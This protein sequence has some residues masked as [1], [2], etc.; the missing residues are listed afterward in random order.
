[1]EKVDESALSSAARALEKHADD[2]ERFGSWNADAFDLWVQDGARKVI[3]AYQ[4][5]LDFASKH[6]GKT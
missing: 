2:S 5:A 6:G 3:E 1:M 4:A